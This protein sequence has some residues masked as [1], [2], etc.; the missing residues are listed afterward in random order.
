MVSRLF[1]RIAILSLAGALFTCAEPEPITGCTTNSDCPEEKRCAPSSGACVVEDVCA[2]GIF[3]GDFVPRHSDT[4]TDDDDD[5][6]KIVRRLQ[7]AD[8]AIFSENGLLQITSAGGENPPQFA[9]DFWRD[10]TLP[11]YVEARMRIEG[12]GQDCAAVLE[13]WPDIRS[14]FA[15]CIGNGIVGIRTGVKRQE[16]LT[17]IDAEAFHVIRIVYTPPATEADQPT[18]TVYVDD[19]ETPITPPIP[20]EQLG[21]NAER[22]SGAPYVAFGAEGNGLSQ[23]DFVRFG[24]EPT[25]GACM[26]H[27]GIEDDDDDCSTKRSENGCPDGSATQ[28]ESCNDFDDDCDGAIDENFI[29]QPPPSDG[30]TPRGSKALNAAGIEQTLFK[31]DACIIGECT[32]AVMACAPGGEDL[33]CEGVGEL[34]AE[35]CDN[36]DND[37]DG[38]IDE[39]FD[40][41]S[42]LPVEDL[43][44][45]D[46][47]QTRDVTE[48]LALRE[49]CGLGACASAG[50][51]VECNRDAE[52]G[53]A[54]LRCSARP[55]EDLCGDQVDNDC[56]GQVDETFDRDV[57]GF[58]ECQRCNPLRVDPESGMPIPPAEDCAEGLRV[59][60]LDANSDEGR[61]TNPDA[62]EVCDQNDNDCDGTVDEGFD[63]D[64][65]TFWECGR[66]CLDLGIRECAELDR[67]CNPACTDDVRNF[68][69]DNC[70]NPPAELEAECAQQCFPPCCPIDVCCNTREDCNDDEPEIN[71]NAE[72]RCNRI[73]DNCDNNIDEVFRFGL[74]GDENHPLHCGECGNS[75]RDE[76]REAG[77][78]QR[79]NWVPECES[80]NAVPPSFACAQECL[81]NFFNLNLLNDDG[82]ECRRTVSPD[83]AGDVCNGINDDCDAD[84]RVDEDGDVP[85]YTGPPETRAVGLCADGLRLCVDGILPGE[86]PGDCAEQVVPV[87]EVCNGLDDD[88]DGTTDEDFDLDLDGFATCGVPCEL[89]V[90]NLSPDLC[91]PDCDDDPVTGPT[92]NRGAPEVCNRVDDDC[93]ILVDEDFGIQ[94]NG[95]TVYTDLDH[96]GQCDTECA[97]PNTLAL[98]DG[99]ESGECQ[100]VGC[101]P[102]FSDRN[103]E[104]ADGCEI[105]SCEGVQNNERLGQACSKLMY[106]PGEPGN[107]ACQCTGFFRCNEV[108][109]EEERDPIVQ[110]LINNFDEEADYIPADECPG[111]AERIGGEEE[112]CN[113]SDDDCDGRIDEDFKSSD[114]YFRVSHCGECNNACSFDRATPT[115]VEGLCVQGDCDE[116]FHDLNGDDEDGCEYA[117]NVRPPQGGELPRAG[118]VCNDLDDDC[119]GRTD[120][121]FDKDT[122][123]DNCGLCGNECEFENATAA[124]VDGNCVQTEC[125]ANFADCTEADGCETAT[126]ADFDRCGGCDPC[127]ADAADRC[128]GGECRCGNGE[129]CADDTPVCDRGVCVGCLEN[130]HCEN[131]DL[132]YCVNNLCTECNPEGQFDNDDCGEDSDTPI[133]G[134]DGSCRQCNYPSGECGEGRPGPNDECV[135][136]TL[137]DANGQNRPVNV[138]RA[139]ELSS[140]NGCTGDAPICIDGGGGALECVR[141]DNAEAVDAAGGED[142]CGADSECTADGSCSGCNPQNHNGCANPTP[143]CE[144]DERG[145]RECR[146]CDTNGECTE[147]TQGSATQCILGRCEV[148]NPGTHRGCDDD[149]ICCDFQCRSTSFEADGGGQG[150]TGC[151]EYCDAL[152]AST[153]T[154]RVCTCGDDGET[155]GGQAPICDRRDAPDDDACANC[156]NDGDCNAPLGECV[157]RICRACDP[158]NNDGC[159]DPNLPICDDETFVC[160]AACDDGVQNGSETDTDCGG[161]CPQCLDNRSCEEHSDCISLVCQGDVCQPPRCNDFTKNGDETDVDCGGPACGPCGDNLECSDDDDCQS[162]VC[163]N[164]RCRG[165]SCEDQVQNG[166]ETDDDCGG[167]ACDPCGA[168]EGCSEGRDCDTG[169]CA[170]N[171]T[172]SGGNCNDG[173]QNGSETDTDCGGP[174]CD[175]CANNRSCAANRDCTSGVCDNDTCAVPVCNDDTQNG[176]ET[177][178]DCGGNNACD[179]CP[180]NASCVVAGDCVSGVC[181]N[182]TCGGAGC[183]DGVQNG[184]ETATDCGGSCPRCADNLGCSQ[185][186]DCQ[187]RVCEDDTCSSP[188]CDDEFTNG[189]ETDTDCGGATCEP[190][191]AG[192]NCGDGPDCD[193]GVCNGGSCAGAGC[194]DGVRN[195]NETDVDCGGNQ[196]ERCPDNRTC[197]VNNDCTSLRCPDG[198]CSVPACDDDTTNGQ[199]TDEDCGGP[200]CQ[201][202]ADN[203]DC[204]LA[205]DCTSG[206]CDG[207]TCVGAGCADGVQNGNETDTDC[208]GACAACADNLS[209][210]ADG[211][212]QSAVC[213]DDV[214]QVPTCQDNTENGQETGQ[215]CG[216]PLCPKC[217]ANLGCE[218]GDDCASGVCTNDV[219]R[220]PTC[221][222]TVRNGGETDVDCGGGCVADCADNLGC[223]NPN[224]CVSGVC[225]AGKCSVP[226]CTDDVVNGTETGDDNA[227]DREC[228]GPCLPCPTNQPCGLDRDCVSNVCGNND[229]C[230]APACDDSERN[231]NETDVDCGPGCSECADNL[232]CGD[233]DDNCESGVCTDGRCAEPTCGDGNHNGDETDVDCGGPCDRCV[234][235]RDCVE[236]EDCVSL[237]CPDEEC[238]VPACADGVKN[239]TET[240]VDCGGGCAPAKKCAAGRAC[241][242]AGHCDSGVCTGNV[243]QA[244]TCNDGAENGSET[245]LNCGGPECDPCDNGGGCE[246]PRDCESGVCVGQSCEAADCDDGVQ[247]GNET[248]VDCGGPCGATCEPNR[249]CADA[250]DC[251]SGVCP[252]EGD[253]GE[254][255]CQTPSC[256]DGTTNGDETASD[257]GGPTCDPCA[258]GAACAGEDSNCESGVC[259]GNNLCQG[260]G[261]GDGVRNGNE[262]DVDC[263]G[264]NCGATCVPNRACLVNDDCT[265]GVCPAEGEDGE[266]VCQAPDCNDGT[267]N[268]SESA[269]DCGGQC[270][271]CGDGDACA[272]DGD[273]CASGVC[274]GGGGGLCQV[275]TCEDDVENGDESDVDCGQTCGAQRLCPDNQRCNAP[276]DCQNG[277]CVGGRCAPAAC[278]DEV[279]NGDETAEDC[280][281]SC[282]ACPDNSACEA[283][284]DCESRLCDGTCTPPECDDSR[285]NGAESD[286]DCG[287]NVCDPCPDNLLCAGENSN[288]L[289]GVCDG[290]C[291][292]PS[293]DPA[294][295]VKNGDESDI[296]CGGNSC[297]SCNVGDNCIEASDCESGVCDVGDTDICVAA[298]C[299]DGVINAPEGDAESDIDCG[300]ATCDGCPLNL[301]CTGNDDCASAACVDNRCA[302]CLADGTG[303]TEDGATP[304]CDGSN[305]CIACANDT[306][307]ANREGSRDICDGGECVVCEAD[308]TG[309]EEG[310]AEPICN[311]GDACAACQNHQECIDREGDNNLCDN[312]SCVG[313]LSDTDCE[314]GEACNANAC[315]A[316][317]IVFVTSTTHD[318]DFDEGGDPGGLDEADAEC[319]ARAAAGGLAGDYVAWLSDSNT[320]ADARVNQAPIPFMRVD[321]VRLANTWAD[322]SD[323]SIA[324][325]INVNE[326]GVEVAVGG[327][328]TGTT[329][330]GVASGTDCTDWT[331]NDNGTDGTDGT[332][333][334]SDD[335]WSE[336]DPADACDALYR[337]YC[338][339]I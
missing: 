241:T 331:T 294:D 217:A 65:D 2:S 175:A 183:N 21:R 7:G 93:D 229:R 316:A 181:S 198:T 43:V 307:C 268:G 178:E 84:G 259:A 89:P 47:P 162:A 279:E 30:S 31:G 289:S 295:G 48:A 249:A 133:C 269:T 125:G 256:D 142:P 221:Q 239:G 328:W 41:Q 262:T 171:D 53:D 40:R 303:C 4:V 20:A 44:L 233:D 184:D 293:C 123:V 138:C 165:S 151:G 186:T 9:L 253:P 243:C 285:L 49:A 255:V 267:M 61:A 71:P 176:S 82:C 33:R 227:N 327:V 28:P 251:T 130:R 164:G 260:P 150:C 139:C 118:E 189:D 57:D 325:P 195:G 103:R 192:E 278:D 68:C 299:D 199:E 116:G 73:D 149:E 213:D 15:L 225:N 122:E 37:C 202:C 191:T 216:G 271:P 246:L 156:S 290:R 100:V 97:L 265:S 252:D 115:C 34:P 46:D 166:Q 168:G 67:L 214:C 146:A 152:G 158:D 112:L 109:G 305:E 234:D 141:C 182:N 179:R 86:E 338:V 204:E 70:M 155:C 8:A 95:Q 200:I 276:A 79:R 114:I 6:L 1:S 50:G 10:S 17:E 94:R 63:A 136:L 302:E 131:P 193:T 104:H 301:R 105:E 180:N 129:P 274:S 137:P 59:D 13:L 160:R 121:G 188:V 222:D 292:A 306:Q 235:G 159:E 174:T 81:P 277:R 45:Y 245:G 143:F 66:D 205:R 120:E 110:C 38:A 298:T 287:G 318:G 335:D 145:T 32:D 194:G 315:V 18:F 54:Q 126:G 14:R 242:A 36:A 62:I 27:D 170:G 144:E 286:V 132:P 284:S 83:E 163:L 321:K 207:N 297:P 75:C 60:C 304:I 215:D 92:V 282:D 210:G 127:N 88:C 39:D 320:N 101:V 339:Q 240:D 196:C 80:D 329:A 206:R 98:P 26:P 74:R 55:S 238:S 313:C 76:D 117:C 29:N 87:E 69:R 169:V 228:G 308:G 281:G 167:P 283:D 223:A 157:S 248:D 288:C 24:C 263:G 119:D 244:P 324:V 72:E 323:G 273:N 172:C 250:G 90:V 102:G 113:V 261:C 77:G 134:T 236:D 135:Q 177:D 211:D 317:K 78:Q 332:S 5:K 161:D 270:G 16:P 185:G 96:C 291:Q 322:F 275:R 258:D 300:G 108:V 336:D 147:A 12:G 52:E 51:V 35:T 3:A 309:C 237:V 209:C 337:L 23:W 128:V 231:G 58:Q 254:G 333:D 201:K 230:T 91:N 208:G 11:A 312:G 203:S 224:D 280:G 247:N 154:D 319:A 106:R 296:D 42:S 173:V 212:C 264:A 218:D 272:N 314:V 153:C 330:A 266:F 257:C 64:G 226:D 99:C 197:N 19:F 85:C 232:E 56:D 25:G 148:C 124:C 22:P 107:P 334:Q 190:C 220:E 326:A 311:A 187:S 310:G 140:N 111:L 219:C